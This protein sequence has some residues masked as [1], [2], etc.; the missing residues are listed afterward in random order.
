MISLPS[1]WGQI[2]TN[3][4]EEEH[5]VVDVDKLMASHYRTVGVRISDKQREIT[6]NEP[7]FLRMN[8]LRM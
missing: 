4:S 7:T 8:I 5:G 6:E 1:G 3:Y 2:L